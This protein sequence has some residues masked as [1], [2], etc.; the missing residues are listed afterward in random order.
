MEIDPEGVEV[1]YQEGLA[2]RKL[3]TYGNPDQTSTTAIQSISSRDSAAISARVSRIAMSLKRESDPRSLDQICADVTV[4]LLLGRTGHDDRG[5]G[6]PHLSV[7]LATLAE[8]SNAPGELAGYGAVIADVAR[9]TAHAQANCEWTYTVTDED[10]DVITTG[11][12]RRR[13][14]AA[15]KRDVH[16]RYQNCTFPG[17]RMPAYDCDLDHRKPFSEG[18][19]THD[20]NLGPLCRHHHMA[21]HH[22]PWHQERLLDGDHA[23]TS[24][25]GHT[26]ITSGRSP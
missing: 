5:G 22:A 11:I 8:P 15:Q 7:D 20:G 14:T 13:N 10:G 12:I 6:G 3:V 21:K 18:G 4:D 26:Y 23:W 9:Q 17:Y 19:P 1:G 25:L 16:A 24:P 2:D